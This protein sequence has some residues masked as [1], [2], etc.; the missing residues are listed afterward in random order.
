MAFDSHYLV[1]LYYDFLH[2]YLCESLKCLLHCEVWIL[3]L[4]EETGGLLRVEEL[5]IG[6]EDTSILL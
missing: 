1:L 4:V 2:I 3:Y 6:R 5:G